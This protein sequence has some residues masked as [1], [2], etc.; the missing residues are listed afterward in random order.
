MTT[1][2]LA[3]AH[4]A[5]R[6]GAWTRRVC[7]SRPRS[8]RAERR[9]LR[10]A[11]WA[12]YWL[13][14]EEL[15]LDARERAFRAYRAEGDRAGAGRVAA[16]LA[17]DH[18]EFRGDDAVARGWLERAHRLLDD[19]VPEC[20]EHGWL[21]LHEGSYAMNVSGDID[22]RRAAQ[23]GAAIGRALG[24]PDLEAS[25][26]RSRAYA[27]TA[28][29][30]RGGMRLL[31]EASAIARGED[32]RMPIAEGWALCYLISACEGVGDFPRAAQWC[33]AVRRVA[34]DWGGRHLLGICRSAYGNVLAT[35]GDWRRPSSS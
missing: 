4:E 2:T 6:T 28:R 5:L 3:A 26:S 9:G 32:L 11:G 27:R 24:P 16:W 14:D 29:P 34:E 18:L 35:N 30:R 20:E 12:G 33:Q 1:D 15:T 23:R 10:G 7:G 13:D 31:D 21:A 8:R 17:S 19:V 25:V 22:R